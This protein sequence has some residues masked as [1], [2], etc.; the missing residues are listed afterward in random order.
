[1]ASKVSIRGGSVLVDDQDVALAQAKPWKFRANGKVVRI[2]RKRMFSF[3]RELLGYDGSE[4]I[5]PLNGDT[6]DY[7]RENLSIGRKIFRE[8]FLDDDGV[9]KVPLACG[10]M[11]PI[12]EGDVPLAA[13]HLWFAFTCNSS[14]GTMH[15]ARHVRDGSE[16]GVVWLHRLIMDAPDGVLVDH[17]DRDGLNNRRAN[18]RLANCAQNASNRDS[19][20]NHTGLRGVRRIRQTNRYRAAITGRRT[21]L[22]TFDSPEGAARA[23][24]AAALRIYGEFAVLNYPRGDQ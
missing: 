16:D 10:R 11:S 6:T 5:Y 23:Y 18:L 3:A 4:R 20:P 21:S 22:G 14:R 24:D 2:E 1:M 17:A 8:P 19:A 9:W 15:V 7:R 13:G 12:D